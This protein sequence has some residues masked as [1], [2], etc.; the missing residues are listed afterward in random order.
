MVVT[1]IL[2]GVYILALLYIGF[3]DHE[4]EDSD[5]FIIADRKVGIIGTLSSASAS[6]RDGGGLTLWIGMG[7]A[8]AYGLYHLIIGLIISFILLSFLAPKARRIAKEKNY[9]TIGQMVKD[10]VGEKTEK[11]ASF[12]VLVGAILSVAVQFFVL[13]KIMSLLLGIDAFNSILIAAVVVA[14]YVSSGGYKSIVKTDILQ[15]FIMLSLW[16]FIFF[17]PIEKE[18]VLNFSSIASGIDT[19]DYWAGLLY[20]LALVFSFPDIWQRMFSAK[21]DKTAKNG[22]RLIGFALLLMTMPLTYIGMSAVGVIP[23]GT[24]ANDVVMTI[25]QSDAYPR[26]MLSFLT[27]VGVSITMSTLDTYAYVFSSTLL[28]NFLKISVTHNKKRY[29]SMSKIVMIAMLAVSAVLALSIG[30]VVNY[31]FGALCLLMVL[32]PL[33]FVVAADLL[34]QKSKQLDL[35]FSVAIISAF[36]IGVYLFVQGYLSNFTMMLIPPVLSTIFL[37]CSYIYAKY[38]HEIK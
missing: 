35:Y 33:F 26:L 24:E 37:T 29:I 3:S 9:L 1:Y 6:V 5:G 22:V 31:M 23:A 21:D 19:S 36:V 11:T 17:L 38:K 4:T 13:G 10:V 14:F 27:I 18:H 20:V 12:I 8:A 7:F 2:L 16:V 34:K 15:F 30:N 25:L 32:S 28:E